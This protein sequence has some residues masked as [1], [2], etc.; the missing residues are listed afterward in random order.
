MSCRCAASPPSTP[1]AVRGHPVRVR[2][3]IACR[4]RKGANVRDFVRTFV[5]DCVE[6]LDL[7]PPVVEIGSRPAETQEGIAYLRD[8]VGSRR[9]WG[10]TSSP[11]RTSTW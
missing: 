11:D 6:Q 2:P 8:L 1:D 9:T 3:P 10:V 4:Q 7:R 5:Q